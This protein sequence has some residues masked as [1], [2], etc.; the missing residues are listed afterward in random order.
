ML[1][2][3]CPLPRS[4]CAS[5]YK[6]NPTRV[7]LYLNTLPLP[8]PA[9]SSREP[10]TL[11]KNWLPVQTDRARLGKMPPKQATLGYVKPS[12]QTLGCGFRFWVACRMSEMLM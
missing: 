7:V 11:M 3:R 1:W 12:Q 9:I 2:S 6:R 5:R 4:V 10:R 8:E